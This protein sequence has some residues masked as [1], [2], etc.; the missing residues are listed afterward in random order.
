VI[1]ESRSEEPFVPASL[2]KLLTSYTALKKLGPSFHFTTRVLA[3]APPEDGILKGDIWIKGGGDPRFLSESALDLAG[4]LRRKGIREISGAIFVDNGF[5]QPLTERVCLDADCRELYNP[6]VSAAAVDSNTLTL[7]VSV[8]KGGKS[9]KA[10]SGLADGY[11]RVS[12]QA[13]AAKKGGGA[14][15]VWSAGAGGNGREDFQVSGRVSGHAGQVREFRFS[16][17]DP[18]GLFAHVMKAALEHSGIRVIGA[19]AGGRQ[20]P[21]GAETIASYESAPLS[22]LIP[23]LNRFSNNFMAEML[24]KSLGGYV[25][26]EPGDSEKGIAVI[27]DALREAGVPDAAASLDCGSGLSR[28]SRVSP[29]LLCRLLV[30]AWNDNGLREEFVSSMAGNGEMGTLRRR[31]HRPGLT[32]KG[33]TGTLKEVIGFAGYVSGIPGRNYAVAA[34][35]NGVQNRFKARQAVDSLIEQVA[36]SGR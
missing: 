25:S 23:G 32:V 15:R 4:E 5:F 2:M 24:L 20:A 1:C 3:S 21:P 16:A 28:S 14:L 19:A 8:P 27:R 10:D 13:G 35:L 22:E 29:E 34:I 30:A 26:G 12:G 17:A 6:V 36:L 11:A 7:R 31:M 33:K 18:A 9:F